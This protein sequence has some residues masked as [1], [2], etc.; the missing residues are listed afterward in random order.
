M[1]SEEEARSRLMDLLRKYDTRSQSQ[2]D[3]NIPPA[4]SRASVLVPLFWRNGEWNV[5]LTVRSKHLRSHSGLVA[6][7]GGKQD[8]EDKDVIATALREAEEEIGLSPND[9]IIVNVLPP[10]F[11]RPKNIVTPVVAII[12]SDFLPKRNVEEVQ[13]VFSLPISR[14]VREDFTTKRFTMHDTVVVA[15][16]FTDVIDGESIQTWGY[17]AQVIMRIALVVL[18][19]DQQR[20]VTDG[21]VITKDTALSTLADS[22]IIQRLLD[23]LK[24]S[25]L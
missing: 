21:F 1:C 12:P 14:F 24:H 3:L 17:T 16:Y 23:H 10:S 7:P 9:V 25:N 6:F 5:L 8:P 20:D 18:E 22:N 19:S 13:K 2:N 11:V 15:Y 4:F